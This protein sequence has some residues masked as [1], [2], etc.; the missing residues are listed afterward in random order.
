MRRFILR[1]FRYFTENNDS[2]SKTPT[3]EM[4]APNTYNGGYEEN[5]SSISAKSETYSNGS[6]DYNDDQQQ[7]SAEQSYLI[8]QIDYP[9]IN[10]CDHPLQPHVQYGGALSMSSDQSTQHYN[11]HEN[12]NDRRN[13]EN[14]TSHLHH[15]H[16]L[17]HLHQHQQ[18]PQHPQHPQHHQQQH[19]HH[20]L[21]PQQQQQQHLHHH[22]QPHH[23][24][25]GVPTAR[26]VPLPPILH[27]R[28]V[29][30]PTIPPMVSKLNYYSPPPPPPP[31]PDVTVFS[32]QNLLTTFAHKPDETEG[33]LV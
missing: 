21:H 31:P 14:R 24:A 23:A 30:P 32:S 29:P 7:K 1:F 20:H 28:P 22:Q 26:A 12:T 3:I 6:P 17:H 25:S 19:L 10:D 9:F 5:L 4:Y 27:N 15:H 2:S 18:H 11:M 33:H 16:H 13:I 8:E